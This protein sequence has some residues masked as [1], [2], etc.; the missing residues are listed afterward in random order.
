M[1]FIICGRKDIINK[2]EQKYG[3]QDR[4]LRDTTVDEERGKGCSIN[5]DRDRVARE[6]VRFAG[7]KPKKGEVRDEILSKALDMSR[8]PKNLLGTMTR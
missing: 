3:R 6:E 7:G 4:T 2:K 5:K 1:H 8:I